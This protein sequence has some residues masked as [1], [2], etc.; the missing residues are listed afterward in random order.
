M[1]NKKINEKGYVG[2]PQKISSVDK[3]EI[4]LTEITRQ[5]KNCMPPAEL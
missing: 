2:I 4:I 3:E 1:H 5:Y